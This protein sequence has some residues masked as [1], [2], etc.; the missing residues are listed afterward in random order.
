[1]RLCGL[2][3][4][5]NKKYIIC[6]SNNNYIIITNKKN[7]KKVLPHIVNSSLLKNNFL[8]FFSCYESTKPYKNNTILNILYF[9]YDKKNIIITLSLFNNIF[10]SY[11][12][13]WKS[14]KWQEREIMDMFGLIFFNKSDKRS[15]FISPLLSLNPL[16]KDSP[17]SGFFELVVSSFN[18]LTWVR[19]VSNS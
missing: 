9:F 18:R 5:I 19:L 1:M 3:L 4:L 8:I 13:L 14:L 6:I 11:E 16:K 2:A 17:T 7:I 12:I 10:K 15:L